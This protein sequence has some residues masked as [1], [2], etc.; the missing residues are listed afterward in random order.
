MSTAYGRSSVAI[1]FT[2]Q[3]DWN[4]VTR[5]LPILEAALAP[6]EHRPHW[7]KVFTMSPAEVRSA[8]PALP[9]FTALLDRSDPAG[10]FR[11]AFLSRY[12]FD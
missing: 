1:H 9:Q 6:F 8:Y 12:L 4:A 5:M 2:W 10:S 11:N 7:G 3:R